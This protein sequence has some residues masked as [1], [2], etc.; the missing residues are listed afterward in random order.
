MRAGMEAQLSLKL[1]LALVPR[2]SYRIVSYR[3]VTLRIPAPL[4]LAY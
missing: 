3:C 4:V 1:L 2:V